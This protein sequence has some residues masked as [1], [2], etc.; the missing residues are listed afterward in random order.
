MRLNFFSRVGVR[1][2]LSGSDSAAAS[3]AAS[4]RPG[5]GPGSGGTFSRPSGSTR[6]SFLS[7]LLRRTIIVSS[8]IIR[9]LA[10]RYDTN[11]LFAFRKDNNH[12]ATGSPTG[13]KKAILA[14]LFALLQLDE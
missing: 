3:T 12:D 9:R 13:Q 5:R 11:P 14:V 2:L 1:G 4:L 8:F 6:T 7:V 10:R